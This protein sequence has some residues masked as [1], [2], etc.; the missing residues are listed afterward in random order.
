MIKATLPSVLLIETGGTITHTRGHDKVLRPSN[1]SVLAHLKDIGHHARVSVDR[2]PTAMDSTNMLHEQRVMIAQK[3][4]D[5][6]HEFDGFVVVHGTDTMPDT[7]AA[8]TYM[9]QGL[10]KPVML[11]GS[12]L[13][14]ND[15]RTD[16]K[17]NLY[18]AIIAA[19]QDY[20]EVG[21]AFGGKV[22]R[23]P[24]AIK[25][26]S[27]DFDAFDSPRAPPIGRAGINIEPLEGRITRK[28][29][30]KELRFF[31]HFD[32]NIGFFY[33]MSGVGHK[34]FASQVKSPDL[35]GFVFVGF[36][37]GNIPEVYYDS[38][39]HARALH[40]PI[41]VVTQCIMGST[42]MGLYEASAKP[43][44]LGVISG[45]DMT[46]QTTTQK[47]MYALGKAEWKHFEGEKRIE[48]VRDNVMY[49]E[50]AKEID[51]ASIEKLNG[52]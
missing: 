12:Q 31:P 25:I 15:E 8:L 13:P 43:L 9:L 26:S 49:R 20:G 50:Y 35:H 42:N 38:L 19:T 4:Y 22:L 29:A 3:I 17:I 10:G 48:Y 37:A 18:S 40:K 34:V 11:T 39:E 36:G 2:L 32:T 47:L 30:A 24:R 5:N 7:A 27:E 44:E 52:H 23:G 51:S 41:V 16:A 1:Q 46:M 33:P 45:G 28:D 14:I 6:A 21:I